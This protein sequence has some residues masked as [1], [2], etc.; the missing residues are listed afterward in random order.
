MRAIILGTLLILRQPVAPQNDVGVAVPSVR[1]SDVNLP[2]PMGY[3][4]GS[5]RRI[6]L[7]RLWSLADREV[8][9]DSAH[10]PALA[11]VQGEYLFIYAR[12]RSGRRAL[13]GANIG[14]E[15]S[16]QIDID[17]ELEL[18]VLDGRLVVYW[19]ETYQNRVYQQGIFNIEGEQITFLC[20]GRGGMTISD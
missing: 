4:E 3:C 20:R 2:D 13:F 11:S 16:P 15:A 1:S 9:I 14:S 10:G 6:N 19:K 18:A 12:G 7:R 5:G 17:V 8:E